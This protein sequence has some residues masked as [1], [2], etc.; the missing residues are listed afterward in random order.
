MT[1]ANSGALI[2]KWLATHATGPGDP[3]STPVDTG[4]MV[5]ACEQWLSVSASSTSESFVCSDD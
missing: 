3:A 2:I 5:V 4:E 1:L